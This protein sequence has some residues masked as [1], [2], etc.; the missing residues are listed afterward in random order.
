MQLHKRKTLQ[1]RLDTHFRTFFLSVKQIYITVFVPAIIL[2][3]EERYNR[4]L[5]RDSDTKRRK[6]KR[7]IHIGF[8]YILGLTGTL[9]IL[10]RTT[11]SRE[12]HLKVLEKFPCLPKDIIDKP[13][14]YVLAESSLGLV[15]PF[16]FYMVF[17]AS[18]IIFFFYK[19]LT[20]LFKTRTISQKTTE[21]QKKLFINLCIQITVPL[22]VVFVPCVYLNISGLFNHLDMLIDNIGQLIISTHGLLSTITTLTVHKG[23]RLAVLHLFWKEENL[24]TVAVSIN[25]SLAPRML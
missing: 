22:V 16:M 1:Q 19:T 2:F 21:M 4:L 7:I 14:F 18:Q 20:F 5:R 17:T 15:V 6:I 11:D 8:N 13:G 12:S 23:Y 9:A 10:F 3:F 25:N 24:T